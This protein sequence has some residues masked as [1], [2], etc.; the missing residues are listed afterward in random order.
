MIMTII[1]SFEHTCDRD[2][3]SDACVRREI[4]E[5]SIAVCLSSYTLLESVIKTK[6]FLE[7]SEQQHRLIVRI[8]ADTY[9]RNRKTGEKI[10]E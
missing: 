2:T 10:N 8:S 1:N 6:P 7:Q 4:S 9:N 3:A 5:Y